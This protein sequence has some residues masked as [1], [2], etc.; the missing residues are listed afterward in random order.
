MRSKIQKTASVALYQEQQGEHEE[1]VVEAE[2]D[3]LDPQHQ[4]PAPHLRRRLFLR[5]DQ[6]GPPPAQ[7]VAEQPAVGKAHADQVGA[8]LPVP[9]ALEAWSDRLG[10][11]GRT[12]LPGVRA[13]LRTTTFPRRSP[14]AEPAYDFQYHDAGTWPEQ[15]SWT[16]DDYLRLPDDG[17]RYEII[18]GVLYVS[19][20]PR[21]IHQFVASRLAHFLS[22]FVLERGLGAVLTA[23]LDV[24]L[25]GIASPV[26]P[27][28]VFLAN[29]NL[30]DVEEA[31][32][33]QGVPDLLVEVLSPGN[34]RV[35][36]EV[37][38]KAY[39]QAGVPEYWIVNPKRRII[40]LYHLDAT[41][42]VYQELGRFGVDD[43]VRS[44]VLGGF[45]LKVA[46]LFP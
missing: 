26:Q 43:V 23:P 8:G 46:D 42:H 24:L 14:M 39:E 7:D 35:D 22:V 29:D 9:G 5:H 18:H 1:Q 11:R 28:I 34:R 6:E 16:W 45:E 19:P 27:D 30:P 37:K 25:P 41:R 20:A 10:L 32:N 13:R 4:V 44:V 15:G 33:F 2:Q 40:L 21:F 38:L 17:Q 36:L 31:L 12:T 3:V